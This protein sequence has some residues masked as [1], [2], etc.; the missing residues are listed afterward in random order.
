MREKQ[1][2]RK[3]GQIA[4]NKEKNKVKYVSIYTSID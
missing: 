4:Q 2:I 1:N 3:I